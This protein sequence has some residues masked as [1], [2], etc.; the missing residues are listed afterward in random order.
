MTVARNMYEVN[1]FGAL[2]T[3][4]AFLPMLRIHGPGAR[5]VFVGS[6]AGWLSS[7][8]HAIYSSTKFAVR[9]LS[10]GLRLEV[11]PFGIAV[12]NLE[13][14]GVVTPILTKVRQQRT[15]VPISRL[16]SLGF[17]LSAI[18]D[19]KLSLLCA[20]HSCSQNPPRTLALA[21]WM[22]TSL[23]PTSSWSLRFLRRRKW[24]STMACW[25]R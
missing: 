24:P 1:V 17:L 25:P 12:S 14:G 3:V 8:I 10:D 4:R 9:A 5:I 19:S 11:R 13:P 16:A 7:P 22:T 2:E 20:S 6:V 23:G 15:G 21:L 18:V